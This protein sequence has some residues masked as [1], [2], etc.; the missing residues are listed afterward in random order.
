MFGVKIN[1]L[2]NSDGTIQS[3]NKIFPRTP[4]ENSCA[5]YVEIGDIV[6]FDY[7]SQGSPFIRELIFF[8]HN[9]KEINRVDHDFGESNFHNNEDYLVDNNI[10]FKYFVK[11]LNGN[12]I[13]KA[14]NWDDLAEKLNCDVG[15]LKRRFNRKI[16]N[17]EQS[18]YQF[19]VTRKEL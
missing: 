10:R 8:D 12:V 5:K 2:D 4:L 18:E 6:K 7:I 3:F 17:I 15:I 11:D 13:A 9:Y 1:E 16:K 14:Y 19:I